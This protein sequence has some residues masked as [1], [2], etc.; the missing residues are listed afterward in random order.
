MHKL[1]KIKKTNLQRTENLRISLVYSTS[2]L[3][4]AMEGSSNIF[5]DI[6]VDGEDSLIPQWFLWVNLFKIL[7]MNNYPSFKF[8]IS[9]YISVCLNAFNFCVIC[10]KS[11]VLQISFLKINSFSS[12]LYKFYFIPIHFKCGKII[13]FIAG[14]I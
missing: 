2:V 7:K 1:R 3:I 8:I 6:I 11:C 13:F 14:E 9:K 12:L 10:W 5:Y 4:K